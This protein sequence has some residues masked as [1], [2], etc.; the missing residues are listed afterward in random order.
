MSGL[1]YV[2]QDLRFCGTGVAEQQNVDVSSDG[3]F[4]VDVLRDTAK[5]GQRYRCFDVFVAV[6]TRSNGVDDLPR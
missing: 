1:F 3:M 6:D 4:A 5:E 2:F